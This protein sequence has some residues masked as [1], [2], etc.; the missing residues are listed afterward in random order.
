MKKALGVLA[1]ATA[2]AGCGNTA[3]QTTAELVAQI[4]ATP[5]QPEYQADVVEV[6]Y[7]PVPMA[8]I[9]EFYRQTTGLPFAGPELTGA[10]AVADPITHRCDIWAAQPT[11]YMDERTVALGHEI[12]H[13]FIGRYHGPFPAPGTPAGTEADYEAERQ[14]LF[15]FFSQEE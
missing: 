2:L 1:M 3:K 7:H 13:C 8:R 12:L 5:V 15:A 6:H 4:M 11:H 14:K 10:M 9:V